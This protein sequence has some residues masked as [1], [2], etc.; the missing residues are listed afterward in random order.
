MMEL[1]RNQNRIINPVL[2]A[3]HLKSCTVNLLSLREKC[4]NTELF[5]VRIFLYSIRIQENTDQKQLRIWTLF[6]QCIT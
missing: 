2:K 1:L 4:P 5:L 6:T 3:F